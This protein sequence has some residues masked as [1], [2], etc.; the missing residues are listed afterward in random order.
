MKIKVRAGFFSL[1]SF[2]ACVTTV[3]AA[4]NSD[5]KVGTW[6]NFC[7]GA[8]SHTFDDNTAN[9][10][11]VA[12]PLFDAKGFHMTL[13]TVTGS[14]KF[15]VSWDNMKNAFAKGHEIASHSATHQVPMSTAELS[16]SQ[17]TIREN[18]PGEKCVSLAYPNC[19][20][21][22]E[23]EVRKYYIAGRVCDNKI[24]DS[25]PSN[26]YQI[27][28]F[29][30]GGGNLSGASAFNA[31]ADEA[32][33]KHGWCVLL[34][35]GVGKG[36][37]LAYTEVADIEGNLDYLDK[38]R[39]KIWVE[40]F[41]NVARYIKERNAAKITVTSSSDESITIQVADNLDD[42]IFNYPL[43]IR[44]EL[45]DGWK[46]AV[47]KREGK[48]VEDTIVTVNSKKY[49]MFKAVPDG[50]EVVISSG[51]TKSPYR[52]RPFGFGFDISSPVKR[53]GAS[54]VID[55]R[56][57]SGSGHVVTLFDLIG[58]KLARYCIGDDESRIVL[59]VD[60]INRSAVLVK[61]TGINTTY[62]MMLLL[63]P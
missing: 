60:K 40:S 50:G 8:F 53:L 44:C 42:S 24:V 43:S 34:H 14:G 30:S 35:H 32:V 15:P 17:K 10:T 57:F 18:V 58:K 47:V 16:P 2:Y 51:A 26:F 22:S 3:S 49:I 20:Y 52:Y 45:P 4:A 61:I 7:L 55:P 12:Q 41:G 59:P 46:S 25:T 31:K 48:D 28:S 9:Q 54:L 62:C 36:D 56:R 13:F 1:C 27:S 6:G 63:Q 29:L 33:S 19:S 23:S 21:I 5:F 37:Y 38:N 11:K 39:D